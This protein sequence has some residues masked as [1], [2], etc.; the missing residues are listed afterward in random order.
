MS[1]LTL[2]MLSACSGGAGGTDPR[3]VSP[4][5]ANQAPVFT[6][7]AAVNVVENVT[8][9]VYQAT[10]T[11]A[12]NDTLTYAVTGGSDAAR[13]A[14]TASGQVSFVAPPN[15]DLPA[16]ADG[17]NVYEVQISVSDG[18]ATTVLALAV[19]VTNS[20]EGIAVRR[21][22]TGFTSPVA[23]APVSDTVVLVAEKGG[24]IYQL[25]PQT[26][27]RTLLVQVASPGPVGVVAMAAAPSFTTDGTFFVMYMSQAG[28]LIVNRYL[29]NNAGPTVPDTFGPTL[30]INAAQYAGGGWLGYDATGT[31]L[32]ATGD[33]G[34]KGDPTGSAQDDAS[35]LGKLL[36]IAANPDPYAGASPVFFL[37]S[38]IAKG[39]H[40]P[41]GGSLSGTGILLADHGQDA[42]EEINS[43]ATG[44]TAGNFGWPFLEG[45]RAVQGTAP[46]GLTAP[47][48]EYLRA[49]GLR[50]GQ[51]IVGGAMGPS[52]IPS[53]RS[54][55]V[56]ADGGGAIFAINAASLAAGTT[57][58][59]SMIE[60]RDA[61]FAPDQ[62][63]ID[64][65]V[66][67]TAGPGGTLYIL[68]QD[69]EVFRVDAG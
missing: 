49:S 1:A 56:F 34:G 15:F 57:A 52:A 3:T 27:A 22:A 26:G 11:D 19:T 53:L 28:S 9:S 37:I 31:L 4:P 55:Y 6:S 25:N 67:V 46:A 69:G 10:A 17:N 2:T 8:G 33:A 61:D 60:R 48:L 62:G 65:P 14:I 43:I 18:K 63:T 68:D 41:N 16:D 47:V 39:F 40:Q 36:R 7:S 54:Q 64:H 35:R 24:A 29:R 44:A 5:I 51:A 42:A 20:K 66:A 32:A 13:F 12:N 21:V 58:S 50:T 38:T 23:M 59:A 45:T 30:A